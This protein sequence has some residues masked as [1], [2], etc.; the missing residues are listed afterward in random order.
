MALI[1][2]FDQVPRNSYRNDPRSF[3]YD[4]RA[5]ALAK[6]GLRAGDLNQLNTVETLFLLLPLEHSEAIADQTE[7][8][9]LMGELAER[10]PAEL[11]SFALDILEFARKHERIVARFGRFPHRNQILGRT[12]TPEELQFLTEPGSRF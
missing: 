3:A 1:L 6:Q 12:S 2:L 4:A 11:K 10:A 8:V 7:C 5:L 9:R